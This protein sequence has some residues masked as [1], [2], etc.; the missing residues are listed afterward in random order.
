MALLGS[1]HHCSALGHV[2]A[3][4]HVRGSSD[5]ASDT[6]KTHF[7][8]REVN[9]EEMPDKNTDR[10]IRCE[11]LRTTNQHLFRRERKINFGTRAR[12]HEQDIRIPANEQCIFLFN[13]QTITFTTFLDIM[14]D[15]VRTSEIMR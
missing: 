15:A 3:F 11:S 5:E 13:K 1:A 9:T 14:R 12:S 6:M 7:R 4:Q 10:E 8:N 2:Q